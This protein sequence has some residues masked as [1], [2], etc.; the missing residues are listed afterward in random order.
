[1]ISL[2]LGTTKRRKAKGESANLFIPIQS[3]LPPA[4]SY[5]FIEFKT[6][7][8]T[9]YVINAMNGHSFRAHT[10]HLNHFTDIEKYYNLDETY[11]EPKV[12]EYKSSVS[13]FF[14]IV[15]CSPSYSSRSTSEPGWQIHRAEI[16][17]RF[18][19]VTTFLCT[20]MENH[21]SAKWH[22]LNW[23]AYC[24]HDHTVA[25]LDF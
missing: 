16:S 11:V 14:R 19:E 24:D 4:L 20:G 18:T 25:D 21:L 10:F 15:L 6:R 13:H 5:V 17:M 3:N 7:D 23:W 12:E 1:M 2:C 9:E 8:E 22:R